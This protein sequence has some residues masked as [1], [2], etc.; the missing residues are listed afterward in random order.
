MRQ[1]RAILANTTTQIGHH[2]CSLV[3]RRLEDLASLSHIAIMRRYPAAVPVTA[4]DDPS[5]DLVIANGEGSVHDDFRDA[6]A[7]AELGLA[8][9]DR[10]LPAYLVNSIWESIGPEVSHGLGAFRSIFLRDEASAAAAAAAGVTS[11]VVPDLT[12]SWTPEQRPASGA[13]LVVTDATM[14][15]TRARLHAFARSMGATYLPMR[16]VPAV[17]PDY[18]YCNW[19]R[20]AK[21]E[22]KTIA[23]LAAPGGPWR[24]GYRSYARSFEDFTRRLS[25]NTGLVVSGRFHGLCISLA[26]GLPVLAVGSN[27]G[28]VQ[29]LLSDAH[30]QHRFVN[31]LD[32]L[33]QSLKQDGLSQFAF[34]AAE[35]DGLAGFLADAQDRARAMFAAIA[36]DTLSN[37]RRS[38]QRNATSSTS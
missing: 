36:E 25:D 37:P 9:R 21:F 22:A 32:M 35:K 34:T 3:N 5:I 17:L 11:T 30:L 38:A 12:L 15:A 18:P 29:A 4:L 1:L 7:L 24:A 8:C 13:R 31:D 26:L 10:A 14:E 19:K 6:R 16:T 23:A 2:G 27:T 20:R 28:K 33:G